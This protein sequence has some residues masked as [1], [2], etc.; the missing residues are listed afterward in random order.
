MKSAFIAG[1]AAFAN[2]GR[3]HDFFAETNLIC[4][5]CKEVMTHAN[6]SNDAAIDEIYTLFPK[7]QERINAF[8][9]A[10]ELIDFAQAEK[11][12]MNMDLCEGRE[13]IEHLL[14]E[15]RPLDLSAH[16]AHV[17]ANPNSSWKAELP[18]RFE[19]MSRKEVK[20]MMGTIV[21]PDWVVRAPHVKNAA[22]NQTVPTDFNAAT[23]WPNCATT[24]NWSR[25]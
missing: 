16:V 18:K 1:L 25:D 11:T 19:G 23:F 6:N 4:H 12:C 14:L 9:G 17:N 2:A 24:I 22:P 8:Q 7:L 13:S 5:L 20:R 21:D 3:V 15:E 10:N